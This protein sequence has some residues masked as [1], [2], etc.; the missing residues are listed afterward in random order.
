MSLKTLTPEALMHAHRPSRSREATRTA[1]RPYPFAGP[2]RF[3]NRANPAAHGGCTYVQR[4]ACGA[5]RKVNA[6]A[7]YLEYGDWT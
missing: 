1:L 3:D 2:V 5:T 7:G 6:S 4:C